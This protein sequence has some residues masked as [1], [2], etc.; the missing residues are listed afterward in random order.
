MS[1][2]GNT[3]KPPN[4]RLH[5]S[6]ATQHRGAVL[7]LVIK[8][9]VL[10]VTLSETTQHAEASTSILST[11]AKHNEVSGLQEEQAQ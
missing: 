5:T 2:S 7:G 9:E 11:A 4:D 1:S 10:R 6:R 8:I 3:P